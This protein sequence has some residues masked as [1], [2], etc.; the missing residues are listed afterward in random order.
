M[1]ISLKEFMIAA[2]RVSAP[3]GEKKLTVDI[4]TDLSSAEYKNWPSWNR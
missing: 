3:V 4:E 1:R 2:I